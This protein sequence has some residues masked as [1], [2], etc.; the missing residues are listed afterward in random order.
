[1][2]TRRRGVPRLTRLVKVGLMAGSSVIVVMTYAVPIAARAANAAGH[3]GS[4]TVYHGD[5]AGSGSSGVV[6]AVDTSAAAWTSPV[7]D[8]QLYGEPLV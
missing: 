4:W 1:M 5:A 8:G 7:L 6:G 2:R 3:H